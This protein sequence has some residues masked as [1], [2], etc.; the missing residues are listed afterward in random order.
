[1]TRSQTTLAT[2]L[3]VLSAALIGM[4]WWLLQRS[5]CA[6]D[7]KQGIGNVEEAL[8]LEGEAFIAHIVGALLLVFGIS[9]ARPLSSMWIQLGAWLAFLPLAYLTFLALS[10]S[11]AGTTWACTL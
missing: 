1:M 2:A 5:G 8:A 4:A 7:L 11:A 10:F 6:A 3:L 9:V